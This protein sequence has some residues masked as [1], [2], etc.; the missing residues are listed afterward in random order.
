MERLHGYAPANSQA[1]CTAAS[2]APA[3]KLKPGLKSS[4][5][6]LA[7]GGAADCYA[8]HVG[9]GNPELAAEAA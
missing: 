4:S 5:A 6:M 8:E 7:G 9:A 2:K 3:S 1:G